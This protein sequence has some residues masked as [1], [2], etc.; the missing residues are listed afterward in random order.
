MQLFIRCRNGVQALEVVETDA[1]ERVRQKIKET[2]LYYPSWHDWRLM[3]GDLELRCD[4]KRLED[5]QVKDGMVLELR[6]RSHVKIS[7]RCPPSGR[8]LTVVCETTDRIFDCKKRFS[9][10]VQHVPVSTRQAWLR[11][12]GEELADFITLKDYGITSPVVLDMAIREPLPIR[13]AVKTED[14]RAFWLET[15][16]WDTIGDVRNKVGTKPC[17]V[18]RCS[19]SGKGHPD[20]AL[21]GIVYENKE[22]D[23]DEQFLGA[24]GIPDSGTLYLNERRLGERM[25]ACAPVAENVPPPSNAL[26]NRA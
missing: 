21:A 7:I 3:V 5:Y 26:L 16:E 22:L 2:E 18:L 10:S 8:V 25:V 14:G 19:C 6:Q 23:D 1:V 4:D 12:D 20:D 9:D 24:Y 11:P 13:V 17:S 15:D